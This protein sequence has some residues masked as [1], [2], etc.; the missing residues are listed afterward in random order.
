[1]KK[2]Y[3]KALCIIASVALVGCGSNEKSSES[4]NN[5]VASSETNTVEFMP[6]YPFFDTAT[7]LVDASD[8]ILE[9]KVTNI[10][11]QDI[12]ISSAAISDKEDTG[13]SDSF[14]CTYLVYDIEVSNVLKGDYA[15]DTIKVKQMDAAGAADI[16]KDTSYLFTLQTYPEGYPS[17]LNAEQSVYKLDQQETSTYVKKNTKKSNA[18][19]SDSEGQ[20]TLDDVKNAIK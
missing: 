8:L 13:A 19:S 20:F 16:A 11:K 14:V 17:L 18:V 7:D 5:Q 6:D 15:E 12:D 10:S 3:V 4:A 9:G 1:M 2:K